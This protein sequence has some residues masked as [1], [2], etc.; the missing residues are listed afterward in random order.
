MWFVYILKSKNYKKS[1]V[2]FT[3][4]IERR[5][6][7]HNEGKN[8]YTKRFKPW[9]LLKIEEYKQQTEARKREKYYKSKIKKKKL[10]KNLKT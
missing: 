4:N 2:G 5:L 10:K 6:R 1:Y 8:Y 9:I 3:N 7:E